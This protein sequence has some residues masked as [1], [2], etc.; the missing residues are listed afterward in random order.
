MYLWAALSAPFIIK[1]SQSAEDDA[2]LSTLAW[3]DNTSD[4]N[5]SG[6]RFADGGI[7]LV[8]NPGSNSL[9]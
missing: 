8:R 1:S 2:P 4:F 6:V 5:A 7:Q 9:T 3:W